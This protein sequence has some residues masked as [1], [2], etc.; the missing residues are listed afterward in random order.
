MLFCIENKQPII[1]HNLTF[2]I[3]FSWLPSA[4]FC[5]VFPNSSLYVYL[6]GA[7]QYD[8]LLRLTLRNEAFSRLQKISQNVKSYVTAIYLT[9]TSHNVSVT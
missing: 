4:A 5:S 1:L 7:Y 9:D 6:P 3:P 2:P 8:K